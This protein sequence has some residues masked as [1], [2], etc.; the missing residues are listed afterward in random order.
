MV[1]IENPIGYMSTHYKRPTHVVHPWWFGDPERKATCLWLKGLPPLAKTD[2][3]EPRVVKYKNGRGT[4]SPWHIETIR[5]PPDERSKARS[6]TFPG[7]ARAMAE[8]WG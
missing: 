8:Q 2:P 3:V 7:L 5:L 1:A 6:K 4:D